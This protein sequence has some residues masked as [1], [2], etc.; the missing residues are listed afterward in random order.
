MAEARATAETQ[1]G[2]AES[3]VT[4]EIQAEFDRVFGSD[5]AEPDS[6]RN[7]GS[8]SRAREQEQAEELGGMEGAGEEDGVQDDQ[9]EGGEGEEPKA[10]DEDGKPGEDGEEEDGRSAAA[11]GSEKASGSQLSPELRDAARIAGWP[12]ADIDALVG[13]N[14]ELAAKTFQRFADQARDVTTRLME[15]GRTQVGDQEQPGSQRQS[16]APPAKRQTGDHADLLQQVYGESLPELAEK[17]GEDFIDAIV[18]PLV[19]AS[20]QRLEQALG[21]MNDIQA[22]FAQQEQERIAEEIG[23]FFKSLPEE[24]ADLYGKGRHDQVK[25]EQYEARHSIA[26]MADQILAGAQM[27]GIQMSLGESLRRAHAVHAS[28]FTAQ[29][30]RKRL[31]AQVQRR[32][33]SITQRP[34]SRNANVGRPEKSIEAGMRAYEERAAELELDLTS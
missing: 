7:G 32:N 5:A 27:Q 12:D 13:S 18:R 20:E 30:E 29:L 34:R 9:E 2:R 11:Q 24:Y 31:L 26:L 4:P 23:G 19:T 33:R 3:L 21:P 16:A 25:P 15:L 22:R 17:F 14:P 6:G 10:Q 1:A 28:D 8:R